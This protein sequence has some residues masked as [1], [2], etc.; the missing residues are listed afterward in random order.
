MNS[1]YIKCTRLHHYELN[2]FESF[3]LDPPYLQK[4]D[5]CSLY[6]LPRISEMTGPVFVK[7]LISTSLH[8]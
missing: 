1:I 2:I 6:S 3:K 4:L 8:Q 7:K 5:F